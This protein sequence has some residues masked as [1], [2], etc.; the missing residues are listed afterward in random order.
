[1][2]TVGVPSAESTPHPA[3]HVSLLPLL[4]RLSTPCSASALMTETHVVQGRRIPILNVS[5][6]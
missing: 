5:G 2:A 3:M 1:M 6:V 4:P